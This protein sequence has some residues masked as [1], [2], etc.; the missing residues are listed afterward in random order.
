MATQTATAEREQMPIQEI[1][2]DSYRVAYEGDPLA[3]VCEDQTE[4]DETA[5]T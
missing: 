1:A 3:P 4:E 2:S 5:E